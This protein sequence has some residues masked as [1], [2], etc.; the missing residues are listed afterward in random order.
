L[1]SNESFDDTPLVSAFNALSWLTAQYGASGF[2]H[3]AM[4]RLF[5]L[6]SVMERLSIEACLHLENDVL[7]YGSPQS[8]SG[9]LAANYFG[10]CAVLP[11]GPSSGCT[12]ALMYVGARKA[13]TDLCS[14]MLI[15]LA[16]DERDIMSVLRSDMVNEMVLLGLVR[17]ERPDLLGVLPVSPFPPNCLPTLPRRFKP[18]ARPFLRLVDA[19]APK[20]MNHVPLESLGSNLEVFG[21]LFDPAFWGQYVGGTP[22]GEGPG[23]SASHH[24][25]GNDLRLGRYQIRWTT[26]TEGR[27]VPHVTAPNDGSGEWPLFNLHIH[28]K[29]M[30]DFV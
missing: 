5:V 27:R 19:L 2:W 18:W 11:L 30:S 6:E 1:M 24:W 10:R 8:M 14:E 26:D 12:A 17:L 20:K 28:S 15:W 9:L 4:L 23:F 16:R 7:I 25:L 21:Y 29:K 22:H 3:Y 13:L